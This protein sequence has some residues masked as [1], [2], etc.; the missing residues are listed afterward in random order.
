MYI[1]CEVSGWEVLCIS[2]VKCMAGRCSVCQLCS[3]WLGGVV[4]V[5]RV[6]CVAGRSSICQLCGVWQ[7]SVVYISCVM[8]GR[9]VLCISAV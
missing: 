5:S 6:V 9:E 4:Y 2:A 3:V 8:S 7:G 1:S